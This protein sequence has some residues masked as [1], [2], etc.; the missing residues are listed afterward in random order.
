M[1]APLL[2]LMASGS[3]ESVY[4]L[5]GHVEALVHRRSGVFDDDYRMFYARHNE[6]T[7][8]KY[9][10]VGL[11]SLLANETNVADVV[12]ELSEYVRDVDG[13]LARRA[14]RVCDTH[15]LGD[16]CTIECYRHTP[17]SA[18]CTAIHSAGCDNV[19]AVH[20]HAVACAQ[21]WTCTA[22]LVAGLLSAL[23][24]QALQAQSH[25]RFLYF[26]YCY[27]AGDRNNLSQSAA[28]SGNR[29]GTL[30]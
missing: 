11:L 16:S 7:H 2:T 3:S 20:L 23:F 26:A 24:T 14:I 9:A 30:D 27:C 25:V 8:V 12:S 17:Y 28:S 22:T 21:I 15:A 6:P 10:K 29:H 13:E 5:L 1:K 18:C 19:H 4:C